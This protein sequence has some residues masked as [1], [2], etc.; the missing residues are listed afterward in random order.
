MHNQ[1][2]LY[3]NFKHYLV[4]EMHK[5]VGAKDH[6]LREMTIQYYNQTPRETKKLSQTQLLAL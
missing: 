2:R 5:A 3:N 4:P 6:I 1:L